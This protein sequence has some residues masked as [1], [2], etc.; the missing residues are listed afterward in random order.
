MKQ[1][2][3]YFAGRFDNKTLNVE[4][5]DLIHYCHSPVTLR[6]SC[7]PFYYSHLGVHTLFEFLKPENA[8]ELPWKQVKTQIKF[9]HK[10][11]LIFKTT[12]KTLSF[13]NP[14]SFRATISIRQIKMIYKF[15]LNEVVCLNQSSFFLRKDRLFAEVEFNRCPHSIYP[16]Q[17]FS[18]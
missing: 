3:R 18:Y 4:Y 6:L 17:K 11:I 15:E 9:P 5:E 2:R 10:K 14:S 1:K 16:G 8:K 12:K 7:G 13:G